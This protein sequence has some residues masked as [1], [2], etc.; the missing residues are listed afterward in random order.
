[1]TRPLSFG[2]L[3]LALSAPVLWARPQPADPAASPKGTTA[4]DLYANGPRL[5]LLTAEEQ[6]GG[7]VL[8]HRA[9]ADAG[10]TWS[11]PVPIEVSRGRLTGPT[12]NTDPQ[13]VG[14]G[15]W[16]VAIWSGPGASKWGGGPL[17][18]AVS[19]DA[20]KTWSS[21]PKPFDD[22]S[23]GEQNFVDAIA[24]ARGRLHLAWLDARD[25]QQGLRVA[26]SADGGVSWTRNQSIDT[27]TCECCWNTLA[28]GWDDAV[29]ALYRD[30][31]RDM[32][33]ARSDDGGASWR[34]SGWVGEFKWGIQGCPDVG[35][36]LTR[37]GVRGQLHALVFTGDEKARGLYAL[38][39]ADNGRTWGAPVRVGPDRA[40]H[41]DLAFT[42]TALV[43]AWD[44]NGGDRAITWAYSLDGGGT[45]V[46]GGRLSEPGVAAS[47]PKVAVSGGDA[48]V[49][50]T[51]R[52]KSGRMEWKSSV[53]NKG[54]RW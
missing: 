7:F 32:A 28:T 12:R 24:D 22:G 53:L 8:L 16:L 35:G 9:S 49:V 17:Q 39:S 36:G 2:V 31:P 33:L 10:R 51:E 52:D 45:W 23:G 47:H 37:G 1:M 54:D 21:G 42:G 5:E 25:G 6:P 30:I 19:R 29:L 44:V 4:I 3:L 46:E 14:Y 13:I 50:W 18:T 20:G 26:M 27:E 40:W 34:R 43:A 38:A 11:A 41:A 48:V 15:A